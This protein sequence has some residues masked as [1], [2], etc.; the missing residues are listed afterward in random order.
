[1]GIFGKKNILRWPISNAAIASVDRH[2]PVI[3]GA[4]VERKI[5]YIHISSFTSNGD[6]RRESESVW[7]R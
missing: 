5:P 6:R 3:G 7:E 1:M 4:A 2:V